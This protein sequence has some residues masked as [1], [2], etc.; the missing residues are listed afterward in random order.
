MSEVSIINAAL[1]KLAE[2]SIESRNDDSERA[3]V[4][5]SRYD[6]V[7]DAELRRRRWKFSISRTSLAALAAAPDSD[8]ERQ[9][10]VP[11]DF[12][13][14][15]EGGDLVSLPDM[16]DY[17]SAESALFQLEGRTILTNLSAPLAIRYIAQIRD[18]AIFDS[19]FVEA[20]ASRLAFECCKRITGNENEK[21]SC[22]ED[23]RD[24]IR[25]AV[26]ANALESAPQS[27]ADDTWVMAR[28][29]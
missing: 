14:L 26:R 2:S 10:Q 4:M 15:I 24:A 7:R 6:A 27:Q 11:N 21:D 12:L 3:R 1:T 13:R 17:R 25:E 5:N 18:T 22:K 29:M 19:C 16:S 20:L 9:F 23:Y 8:F 28:A